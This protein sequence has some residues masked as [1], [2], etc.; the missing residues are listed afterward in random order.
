LGNTTGSSAAPSYNTNIVLTQ[1]T[2]TTSTPALSHTVTWNAGG[3]AFTNWLSTITCTAAATNSIAWGVGISGSTYQ[4]KYGGANCASP[5]LVGVSGSVYSINGD[6]GLSRNQAGRWSVGN[7]TQDDKTGFFL[8]NGVTFGGATSNADIDFNAASTFDM[9]SFFK[10]CWSTGNPP[11]GTFDTCLSRKNAGIVQ[12]GTTTSN[13]SGTILAAT[14]TTD[15]NCAVVGTAASPSVVNCSSASAG[16][17]SC[18]TNASAATCTINTTAVT[19]NSEIIV[20]EVA[21]E[22]TRL[23]VTC[24][25]S[26]SVTPAILVATK[27]AAT[28]FTINM[29]TIATNPACFNY[30]IIN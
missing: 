8:L 9:V 27:T 2:I 14:Y 11:S 10:L 6:V 25:T 20:Q 7:G 22:G 26:P 13:S 30:W 18:A 4:V 3:V 21:D 15:T 1:G 23:S 12:I 16:A 5:Q 28:G 17:F 29:P 24:N 19:A